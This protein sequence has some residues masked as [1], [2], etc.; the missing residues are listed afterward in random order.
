MRYF[1]HR[2]NKRTT[3]VDSSPLGLT[4][5][6]HPHRRRGSVKCQ[7]KTKAAPK[8]VP[9]W[10]TMNKEKGSI[11]ARAGHSKGP[12]HNE[13]EAVFARRNLK[14]IV[15]K[16]TDVSSA[17]TVSEKLDLLKQNAQQTAST[18]AVKSKEKPKPPIKISAPRQQGPTVRPQGIVCPAPL[19][20]PP[21]DTGS[22]GIK[23]VIQQ[24]ETIKGPQS[25]SKPLVATQS[26][27]PCPKPAPR[28]RKLE[29]K[30]DRFHGN[31]DDQSTI[32]V[33]N[34]LQVD[35]NHNNKPKLP[36]LSKPKPVLPKEKPQVALKPKP[37]IAPKSTLVSEGAKHKDNEAVVG[38]RSPCAAPPIKTK[39]VISAPNDGSENRSKTSPVTSD[40]TGCDNLSHVDTVSDIASSQKSWLHR[41]ADS[42]EDNPNDSGNGS[43][44]GQGSTDDL[45]HQCVADR[46][47][48]PWLL[49]ITSV[50]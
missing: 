46:G 21:M 17:G 34:A 50:A 14:S 15:E 16:E 24:I 38:G 20:K 10:K 23:G 30:L 29:A 36:P 35:Q 6:R 3:D 1:V 47:M 45:Q 42:E 43:I 13:L 8:G 37:T 4:S 2:M 12:S 39:K 48:F 27:K 49:Y 28:P 11:G 19:D 18:S 26:R 41:V 5:H 32:S 40:H 9:A 22:S 33:K 25:L 44:N 31:V 7:L